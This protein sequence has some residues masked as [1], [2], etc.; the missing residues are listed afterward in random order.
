VP[1]RPESVGRR[2]IA[3]W[4]GFALGMLVAPLFMLALASTVTALSTGLDRTGEYGVALVG[5]HDLAAAVDRYRAHYQH[6]PD[7]KQGLAALVPEFVDHIPDDPWN[8]PYVYESTGPQWADVLSYGADGHA[9]GSGDGA[10]VSARFGRLGSRPPAFL[11]PFSTVVLMGLPLAAALAAR[12]WRWC[13]TAL[14]GM[15]AFW[16]LILLITVGMPTAMTMRAA[17]FPVLSLIA[18]VACLVGAI[19]LLRKLVYAPLFTLISVVVAYLLLQYLV[20]A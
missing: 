16:A 9:G 11:H 10:D 5:V 7:S 4:G 8:H 3:T 14:A 17:L 18:G 20:T 6:V 2:R 1:T 19:A 15:S 12:R 13:A